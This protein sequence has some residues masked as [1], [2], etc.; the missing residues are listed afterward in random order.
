MNFVS[1][2]YWLKNSRGFKKRGASTLQTCKKTALGMM[3]LNVI[4]FSKKLSVWRFWV[5]VLF[6]KHQLKYWMVECGFNEL[7]LLSLISFWVLTSW[8]SFLVLRISFSVHV[9][10]SHNPHR[11]LFMLQVNFCGNGNPLM[12]LSA[13]SRSC[14]WCLHHLPENVFCVLGVPVPHS[15][16][17]AHQVGVSSIVIIMY[18]FL[19]NDD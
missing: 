16:Y 8:F 7:A 9:M 4:C 3:L 19:S 13:C 11:T 18:K 5:R 14:R 17:Y 2:I 12:D 1:A 10:H 15:F 6:P